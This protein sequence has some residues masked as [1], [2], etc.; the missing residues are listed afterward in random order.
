MDN[1]SKPRI[2]IGHWP[3]GRMKYF[4]PLNQEGYDLLVRASK[5]YKIPS[6]MLWL[7]DFIFNHR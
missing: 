4:E 5:Q 7:H 1:I 2:R 6:Q 3:H